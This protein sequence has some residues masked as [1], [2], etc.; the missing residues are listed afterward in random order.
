MSVTLGF[1][2]GSRTPLISAFVVA[3]GLAA[4]AVWPTAFR[5][6]RSGRRVGAASQQQQAPPGGLASST[7]VA[8]AFNARS[9]SAGV[10]SN[11]AKP[12]STKLDSAKLDSA[13]P[14]STKPD[15]TKLDAANLDAP[16]RDSAR[17]DSAKP[18]STRP[19][20]TKLDPTELDSSELAAIRIRLAK[21]SASGLVSARVAAV[22]GLPEPEPIQYGR[23][24]RPILSDRCFLCHG[25]DRA[26]Q[27]AGL[28]LDIRA[29]AIASRPNGAAIVPGNAEASELWKRITSHDASK[30]MPTPESGKRAITPDERELL[31]RWIDEGAAYETHW[32]FTAPV[33]QARP[34]VQHESWSRNDIDRFILARLERAGIS[35]GSE[36]TPIDLV[37][38]LYLDLTGLPPTPEETDA[39]LADAQPDRYERLVDRLLTEEPYASRFA[40]RIAV[41][42]LD[43][44]R[45]ADTS[46][47]H[48]DAGR[49]MWLWR[50]WVLKAFRDNKPYDQF[51]VEQ[52]GGDL[53]P[54]A[55]IDQIIA[56]GF[57]RAHV[58]SD[59]G[60]A[61][62]EEYLLE[63]AADRVNTAGSAFLGLS[64]GCA[65]CHDHKFD[66]ITTE[67]FYSLIAFFNSNEEPG[68]YS[69]IPDANRALEPFIEVPGPDQERQLA[70]LAAAEERARAEQ[71]QAGEAE[72]VELAAFVD[73]VRV[74]FTP[75]KATVLSATS[76]GGATLVPQ[77]DGSVLAQ[78]ANPDR[79]DHTI[80]LRTD[81]TG[82]RLLMLEALPDPSNG[83]GGVGRTPNG[84]AVLEGIS[85]EAVSVADPSRRE[86]IE[87]TWAWADYEQENGDFRAVNALS[88]GDGRVWAVRG[89][90]VPGS[91]TAFFAAA[92]PFGFD[93]GTELRVTL[94]YQS[95]YTQH[96][97]GRVRLTPIAA[98]DAALAA[99]PD[100][101]SVW[102]IAGP[103]FGEPSTAY[104]TEY[105]PERETSVVLGKRFGPAAN[106]GEWRFA[107]GVLEGTSVGLAASIGSEFVA[108]EIYAPTA[109]TLDLSFG[110]DDGIVVYLNGHKV[111]ENQTNRGAAPDQDRVS[112]TLA[113]GR[114]FLV[115]KVVN[116]GGQA[117]FY[118]RANPGE[119]VFDRAMV[120]LVAPAGAV[121]PDAVVAAQNAWRTRFSPSYI[122]A[123][124]RLNELRVERETI[125]ASTPRAMVMKELPMPRE[126]F[127]HARGAYD[128]PDKNRPVV[129]RV[130]AV[131]GA[132]PA[133][134]PQNRLGLAQ[135]LV[136]A[137]NPLTTRVTVN[138]VWEIF[139]GRGLVRTSDDFG[140]QGEWPTHP[141]LLDHLAVRFRDGGAG[142][143]P[144][145]FRGLVRD[146]VTSATYRQSSRLRPEVAAVDPE[147]KLYSWYPRQRLGAE[148]IRDQALYVAGLLKERFGG[149]SVKPYQ[150][151][152]LWQEVAMPQSNTRAYE[153]SQGDDLWRRSL[154]TYWKRAA[155]PPTMLTFDAPTREFCST[156][157][158]VTNTPL[159]S[160]ALWND[161]QFVEAARMAAERTLRADGDDRARA[162]LLFRRATGARPTD[163]VLD[164]LVETL[165]ANRARYIAAPEEAAKLL[166]VGM[167]PKASDLDPAE[168]AAWTL[169]ANAVLSSDA[170]IVKD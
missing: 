33:A 5:S 13:K 97:F 158:L 36:A 3:A 15:S 43:V 153:Q 76:T 162:E 123:T 2:L 124:R 138:R 135:W 39:Y 64:V 143:N 125:L 82:L 61:I 126:T 81:G 98:T 8:T 149:P 80:V 21:A 137:E 48:M 40:E 159:Q 108:R 24:I 77:A 92:R 134:A 168:L 16:E 34:A 170:T 46:G 129:R 59:E 60:G 37:R 55:S 111:H 160:L 58:T 63:Y 121:R 144:W 148:S 96:V 56:S 104:S 146:I 57:N 105:G 11:S 50:D 45:Y 27:Q 73:S 67:D 74:G 95:P 53:I 122:A 12:D 142:R 139:F 42:W 72:K 93:G 152:G 145:D 154:Y 17:P 147:N 164:R 113:P 90:D 132:L 66:P 18:N 31:R 157:R 128:Q 140:L 106:P 4:V 107:P 100:A 32:A 38:R 155:P 151:E 86:P 49:Q 120:A 103:F 163:A 69:Q 79:D 78:G 91:R 150:P 65:R 22:A 169:L 109:R 41:S 51:I 52:V 114:N 54:S 161:P 83:Q 99:L 1:V 101:S 62:N 115:C 71:T 20:S 47:I 30:V 7:G 130:P 35:P 26:H 9:A 112:L 156:K 136:S 25:P 131:L 116:T 70:T 6:D 117:A 166:A 44:A 29:E 89:Y 165:A 88:S 19:D 23:D 10:A 75:A 133:G 102:Y 14:D 28:R 85:V 68:I 84:N 167:A 118:H 141:E 87:L 127:V 94:R 110:S 119:S